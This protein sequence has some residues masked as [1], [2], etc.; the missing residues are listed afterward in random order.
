[1]NATKITLRL[2]KAKLILLLQLQFCS[3]SGHTIFSAE[4]PLYRTPNNEE[5]VAITV[6]QLC[7]AWTRYIRL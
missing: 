2:T 3:I 7:L 5:Q 4:A 1:M 6:W